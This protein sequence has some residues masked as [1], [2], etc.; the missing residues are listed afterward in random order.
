MVTLAWIGIGL[1]GLAFI[2]LIIGFLMPRKAYMKREIQINTD[3]QTVF[4]YANNLKKFVE[5]WSPW[6]EKDPDMETTYEG[7][8][9]GVGAVYSWKGD[10]KKVGYGTMKIIAS[11]EPNKVVNFLSFGGRGDAEVSVIIEEGSGN[12]V[13]V[14]W[15]YSADNGYNPIGRIFGSMMDKFLGPDFEQG[16][17]NLK[18]VCEK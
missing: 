18:E 1:L 2:V 12:G 10:P 17:K 9:E 14:T 13:K 7:A 5:H 6:T 16:L 15:E 4:G 11:E 3:K 8:E